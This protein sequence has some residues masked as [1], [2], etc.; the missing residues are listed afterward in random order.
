ME[1]DDRHTH[2]HA[3]DESLAPGTVLGQ[4]VISQRIGKGGMGS[5]YEAT[6]QALTKRVAI[7]VLHPSATSR[8]EVRTRFLREA[9]ALSRI[10]HPHVV[11]ASD[12]GDYDGSPFLVMEFLDGETLA[13]RIARRGALP[14][15]QAAGVILPVCDAIAAAHSLGI[16]HRD[17]KPANIFLARNRLGGETVKV[18]DFGISKFVDE[19]HPD[20]LTAS[21]A[22]LGTV[23]YMSPEQ[24]LGPRAVVPASDQYALGVI[25]YECVT[26]RRAFLGES[27]YPTMRDISDGAFARPREVL[28]S[29]PEA[30]E[31][32][33]LRA[34]RLV[35]EQRF[36]SVRDLACALLPFASSSARSHHE[37]L[38]PLAPPPASSL[39]QLPQPPDDATTAD[40]S[41]DLP[42]RPPEPAPVAAPPRAT[43]PEPSSRIAP[44][45]VGLGALIAIVLAAS[46][47]A[48]VSHH[49]ASPPGASRP[50]TALPPTPTELTATSVP[51]P[52]ESVTT[53][54]SPTL[55]AGA[56]RAVSAHRPRAR[57]IRR[58]TP[59]G[60]SREIGANGAP[61]EE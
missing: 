30:M 3:D 61:I 14:I 13:Q 2:D 36:P 20:Q 10:D 12:F 39:S 17:L 42:R 8:S 32:V 28:P 19:L 51:E 50:T 11:D 1:T 48:L 56:P 4:Y 22:L 47:R 7:K 6:H 15:E 23:W 59:P 52:V 27:L 24:C 26:G 35:P 43:P 33:I 29:I 55:D 45:R 60:P 25:L 37:S 58:E 5:V 54:V 18:L 31:A 40:A 53:P 38:A 46:L 21:A 9:Q 16:I 49:T 34:M 41:L 44:L 57:V